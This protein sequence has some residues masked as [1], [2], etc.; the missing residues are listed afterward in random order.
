[1][2]LAIF[3]LDNTLIAGD[4]DYLWG[5]FLVEKGIVDREYYQRENKRFY[6]EYETGD[7]DIFEFL[8]FSFKP[9][10]ENSM[11]DL[12][13][14]REEFVKEKIHQLMLP[15]AK[16]LIKQHRSKGHTLLIIT[17]TNHFVTKPIADILGIDNLLATDPEI[18]DNRYTGKVSGVPCFQEGKVTRLQSW[19]AENNINMS[20]SWFYSDSHNDLPLLKIVKN[21]IVVDAD[22]TLAQVAL[23]NG[24]PCIS[25]R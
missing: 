11:T 8:Q 15:K 21:P 12:Y 16:E 22:K 24:W 25:L 2:G 7:L 9:L 19:L 18:I 14:W 5:Q 6:Q 23:E 3:D 13:S 20:E 1:L 4:S 10:S 17:A